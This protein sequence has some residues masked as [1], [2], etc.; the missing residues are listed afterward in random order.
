[1]RRCQHKLLQ[2]RL[3]VEVNIIRSSAVHSKMFSS[4]SW[5]S[6][7]SVS[8]AEGGFNVGPLSSLLL[9]VS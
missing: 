2:N 5:Y 9:Q 1:M 3:F 4:I 8:N 7:C 6:F